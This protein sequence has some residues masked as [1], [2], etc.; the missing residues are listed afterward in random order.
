MAKSDKAILR[1]VNVNGELFQP[2]DEDELQ[3]ALE[4]LEED[5]ESGV[6]AEDELDRLTRKGFL[7]GFVTLD[8]DELE[9]GN[10]DERA[11]RL[12]RATVQEKAKPARGGRKA[13]IKKSEAKRARA[14]KNAAESGEI[15]EELE[16]QDDQ[17]E[18]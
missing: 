8:E 13:S 9:G 6:T 16:N 15:D 17:A 5:E 10:A 7:T 3:E 1:T 12:R 14:R 4:A 18:E 2:G 11:T